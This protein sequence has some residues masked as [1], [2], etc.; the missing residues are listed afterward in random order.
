M[1]RTGWRW[2][3]LGLGM[4]ATLGAQ[5]TSGTP[6]TYSGPSVLSR[7]SRQAG[8]GARPGP[9]LQGYLHGSYAYMDGLVGPVENTVGILGSGVSA[10]RTPGGPVI[11]AAGSNTL[12]GGGRLTLNRT[13][14][15]SS[16]SLTYATN[17]AGTYSAGA[18]RGLNQDGSLMCERQLTR[19]WGFFTGHSA[20]SQSTILGLS[21]PTTQRNFFEPAFSPSN[22]ALDARLRAISS[23]AGFY[24][25][26]RQKNSWVSGGSGSL[27]SV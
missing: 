4:V 20:G 7:W 9:I 21:R 23:G 2:L 27:P 22:E 15:R 13:D 19:R 8:N 16:I 3:A 12:V 26:V 17:Y 6:G 11:P 24:F 18:Y 1:K 10:P 14:A 5:P 25:Q